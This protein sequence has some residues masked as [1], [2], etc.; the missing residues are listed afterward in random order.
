MDP[1]VT[2]AL[3]IVDPDHFNAKLTYYLGYPEETQ[4]WTFAQLVTKPT[5]V[6]CGPY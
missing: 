3:T 2:T 4:T 5:T 6:D 1:C